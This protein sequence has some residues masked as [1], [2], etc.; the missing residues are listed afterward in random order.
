MRGEISTRTELALEATD[1]HKSYGRRSA[2]NGLCLSVARGSICGL[3]GPNGAGKTTTLRTVMGFLRPDRGRMTALGLDCWKQSLGVRS[4]VGYLSAD[5]R[6]YPWLTL[7]KALRLAS[8]CHQ[9][10]LGNRG[11][12]LAER[13]SLEPD[14]TAAR[15]S[16]GNLQKLGLVLAMAAQPELL[17]LDEPSSGLDPLVQET[18]VDLLLEAQAAGT[19]VLLSSHTFSEVSRLC[20]TV[21]V[22]KLGVVIAH[23]PLS[24]FRAR[25]AR[26]VVLS[27]G[28]S[29]MP[30]AEPPPG[31]ELMTR[32]E[33]QWRGRWSGD[34]GPLLR[35][36]AAHEIEDLEVSGAE[37]DE[38]FLDLYR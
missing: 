20:Q 21:A 14:L 25:A 22:V 1:L 10:E 6:F 11:I 16:R 7:T 35:W 38:A 3:L 13:L 2:L 18:F 34:T 26:R 24:V 33:N 4:R 5:M 37:L 8:L 31:L 30:P 19:T 32:T 27:F 29:A 23:E 28:A 17:I 12:G 9:K 15:M 36:C